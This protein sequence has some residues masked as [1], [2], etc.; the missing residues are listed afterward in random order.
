MSGGVYPLKRGTPP[1]GIRVLVLEVFFF[2]LYR[3]GILLDSRKPPFLLGILS[4]A[5]RLTLEVSGILLETTKSLILNVGRIVKQLVL[6]AALCKHL[7]L[8]YQKLPGR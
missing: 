8:V 2:S 4:R 1:T 3:G 7:L 5:G 6:T